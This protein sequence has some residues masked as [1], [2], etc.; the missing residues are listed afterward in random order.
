MEFPGFRVLT[1][2]DA[3]V[4]VGLKACVIGPFVGAARGCT[5]ISFP[6]TC[7]RER[8]ADWRYVLVW[9][10]VEGAACLAGTPPPGAPPVAS[11]TPGPARRVRTRG[12]SSPVIR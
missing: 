3:A 2:R 11:S 6:L 12:L 8:S 9:H 10:L 7:V 5:F 4:N 1:G